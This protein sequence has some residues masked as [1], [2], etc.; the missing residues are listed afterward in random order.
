MPVAPLPVLAFR[1]LLAL[2]GT[3]ERVLVVLL[4][5][6]IIGNIGAQV[7]SRYVLGEPL[8]WVEELATY[9]FIWTTFLGASLGLKYERH[10]SIQTFV[11]R[12]PVVPRAL[13]RLLVLGVMLA[14]A[15]VLMREC[16]TV[17]GIES[18]R[19]SI[20]LPIELPV[21]L[22]FSVPLFV[23]LAS[24]AL[25][26]LYQVGAQLGIALG[27]RPWPPIFAARPDEGPGHHD[28]V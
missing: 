1:N 20:S 7:F 12:L 26:L 25:T 3:L 14:L 10:V 11:A 21:S 8:I 27:T 4:V 9:S 15:L 18:R 5:L 19:T 13:L 24:M 6:N 16:W 23:G 28:E 17:M 2:V 22:F